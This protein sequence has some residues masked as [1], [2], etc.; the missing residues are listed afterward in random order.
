MGSPIPSVLTLPPPLN[1]RGDSSTSHLDLYFGGE[2]F[3]SP[4]TPD[5]GS[6]CNSSDSE[7]TVDDTEVLS[8]FGHPLQRMFRVGSTDDDG[9]FFLGSLSRSSSRSFA[10]TS[11]SSATSS[12]GY[13]IDYERLID[14]FLANNPSYST[15]TDNMILL[16]PSS[17]P[18]EALMIKC[19]PRT[20]PELYLLLELNDPDL[21]S[22]PWNPAPHLRCAVER[23]EKV[24]LCM[25]RLNPYDE[26]PFKTVANYIDFFRQM[27]EGL[28]FLHE[29][30][31][32][33]ISLQ[34]ASSYMVDLSSAPS[35]C[36]FTAEF[37]RTKYPVRYYFTD[38]SQARKI[39]TP[40]TPPSSASP[41][42]RR[43]VQDCAVM[44][45]R[46]LPQVPK[47]E[48]KFKPLVKAMALGG[49]GADDARKLFEALC[50]SLESSTL[51]TLA[52]PPEHGSRSN[53][54]MCIKISFRPEL[55]PSMSS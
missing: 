38:L 34:D 1:P 52:V 18:S 14:N 45:D 36:L 33:Q 29:L 48:P 50:K 7:A 54:T 9:P 55:Q 8:Q 53:S 40:S 37:D 42:F 4:Q 41:Q 3:H 47:I 31:I 6:E 22:D 10:S 32:A 27:L 16:E 23:D 26:P 20:T 15:E 49:F 51:D 5:S 21:R 25:E 46:L 12:I 17:V 2:V 19:L 44:I 39:D 11:S 24:F 30:K 43:D 35:T 13:N 28:T